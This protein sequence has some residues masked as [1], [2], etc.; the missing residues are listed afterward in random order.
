MIWSPLTLRG[1]ETIF[2][3]AVPLSGMSDLILDVTGQDR[4]DNP[5]LDFVVDVEIWLMPVR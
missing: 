4:S 3:L 1:N 2:G 5:T